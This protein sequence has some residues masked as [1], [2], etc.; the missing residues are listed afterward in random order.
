MPTYLHI[1]RR[2]VCVDADADDVYRQLLEGE[3][4][5]TFKVFPVGRWERENLPV[6]FTTT[7]RA[8]A[9]DQFS[10]ALETSLR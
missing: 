6:D 8:G 7:V 2:T 1:G 9:V 4:W 5:L 3:D 10:E